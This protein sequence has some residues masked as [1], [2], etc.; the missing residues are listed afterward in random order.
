MEM[1]VA[2]TILTAMDLTANQSGSLTGKDVRASTTWYSGVNSIRISRPTM[3]RLRT[4][5]LNFPQV[6]LKFPQRDP[7]AHMLPR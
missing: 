2:M 6:P 7:M 3:T 5:I 4:Y 1:A